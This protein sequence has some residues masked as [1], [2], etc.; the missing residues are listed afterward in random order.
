ME[1]QF[2]MLFDKM[3]IEM[4]NQ[5]A[6]L[7]E[8]ITKKVLEKRKALQADLI[9]ERKKGNIA[10]LKYDKLIVKENTNNQE[11]RKRETSASPSYKNQPKKQ[12]TLSSIKSNR[13]NAFDTMRSR[14]NSL[15]NL[16]TTKKQ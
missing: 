16:S 5:N 4:Q 11:K 9:E 1:G 8:S 10:Y 2:Q 15:S 13:S 3:K 7:K 12:Q 6:E 14:S